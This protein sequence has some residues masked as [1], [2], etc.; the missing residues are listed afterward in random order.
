MLALG[1]PS[2]ESLS[3]LLSP[4][5]CASADVCKPNMVPPFTSEPRP[6]LLTAAFGRGANHVLRPPEKYVRGWPARRYCSASI[7]CADKLLCI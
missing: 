7:Y 3:P 5:G 1:E 4:E 2:V 6:R